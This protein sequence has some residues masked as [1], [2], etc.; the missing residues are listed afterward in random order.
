MAWALS[1]V[2]QVACHRESPE[3]ER[4]W[5][6][7]RGRWPEGPDDQR[8]PGDWKGPEGLDGQRGPETGVPFTYTQ[9]WGPHVEYK[10]PL[11]NLCIV[12]FRP[13]RHR[14]LCMAISQHMPAAA[15]ALTGAP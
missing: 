13:Q 10:S 14:M 9:C 1:Q 8:E 2:L 11:I 5:P 6:E 12:H 15:L 3:G 4:W 7:G